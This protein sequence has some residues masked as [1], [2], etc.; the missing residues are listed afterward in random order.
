MLLW[1]GTGNGVQR[2]RVSL[3]LSNKRLSPASLMLQSLLSRVSR[4]TLKNQ[5]T[6]LRSEVTHVELDLRFEKI[7]RRIL[8]PSSASATQCS[9]VRTA[10]RRVSAPM[11]RILGQEKRKY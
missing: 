4:C 5:Q 11:K 9:V 1:I 2:P 6:L 3:S 10:R 8:S 7:A